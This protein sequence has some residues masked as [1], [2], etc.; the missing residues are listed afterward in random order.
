MGIVKPLSRF[1]VVFV[2][3]DHFQY[4]PVYKPSLIH[5]ILQTIF[6]RSCFRYSSHR[7]ALFCLFSKRFYWLFLWVI[8]SG[9]SPYTNLFWLILVSSNFYSLNSENISL[10]RDAWGIHILV[11]C[12]QN[13][14]RK[15]RREEKIRQ[16]RQVGKVKS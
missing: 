15:R 14:G 4:F 16:W 13:K 5:F 2:F 8:V 12:W 1:D 9:I 7:Q 6:I 10:S 3:G 11:G